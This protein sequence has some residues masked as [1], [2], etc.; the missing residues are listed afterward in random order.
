MRVL[1]DTH[2]LIWWISDSRRLTAAAR[3]V[4]ADDS[5]EVYVSAASVWEIGIKTQLGKLADPVVAPDLPGQVR[6]QGFAGL[7]ITLSHAQRASMLPPHHRDPFDRMLIAQAV[8]EGVP[9]VSGDAAF[10]VYAVRRI[11]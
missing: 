1:L 9:I 10:D 4:I 8:A 5:T 6:D 3:A 7:D 2:A 11:W